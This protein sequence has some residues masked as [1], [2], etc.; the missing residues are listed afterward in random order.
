MSSWFL[1]MVLDHL[2]FF[3]SI[4]YYPIG[5]FVS[6]LRIASLDDA[7]MEV[8]IQLTTLK[9]SL[10]FMRLSFIYPFHEAFHSTTM[11]AHDFAEH[12]CMVKETIQQVL[13]DL[14]T[15]YHINYIYS[16]TYIHIP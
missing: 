14:L 2:L 13:N 9:F 8:F 5:I 1:G 4:P 3:S 11:M 10:F 12:T 15:T 7:M 16:P 6:H